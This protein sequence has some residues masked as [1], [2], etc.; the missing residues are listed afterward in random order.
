MERGKEYNLAGVCHEKVDAFAHRI[1]AVNS[2]PTGSN[3]WLTR[4][5][6]TNFGFSIGGG[7]AN[8]G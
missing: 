6:R 5:A 1:Y 3:R 7:D 2:L 4:R 8:D